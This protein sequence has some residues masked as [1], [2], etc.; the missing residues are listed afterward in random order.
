MYPAINVADEFLLYV[1]PLLCIDSI[2][3]LEKMQKV[4]LQSM[5]NRCI[6]VP[7]NDK[8]YEMHIFW[9]ISTSKLLFYLCLEIKKSKGL[10]R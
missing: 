5:L 9:N 2:Q 1:L 4:L 8:V 3:L 6:D 10:S 7:K